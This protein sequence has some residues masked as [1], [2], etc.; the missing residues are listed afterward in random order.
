MTKI[1]DDERELVQLAITKLAETEKVVVA[2]IIMDESGE[3]L[4]FVTPAVFN[5]NDE[6]SE[7]EAMAVIGNLERLKT[8]L[9]KVTFGED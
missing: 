6:F 3:A 4:A 1:L 8:M 7:V 2:G 5:E 9:M